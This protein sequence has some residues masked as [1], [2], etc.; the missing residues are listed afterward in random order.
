MEQQLAQLAQS[1]HLLTNPHSKYA[2]LSP[3]VLSGTVHLIAAMSYRPSGKFSNCA[4]HLNAALAIVEAEMEALQ[5]LPKVRG[6]M[7]M[8]MNPIDNMHIGILD[9]L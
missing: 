2:W 6:V 3:A 5:V 9:G 8:D 1:P 4:A 7:E